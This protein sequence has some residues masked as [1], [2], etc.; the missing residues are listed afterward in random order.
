MAGP[1]PMGKSGRSTLDFRSVTTASGEGAGSRIDGCSGS[2]H[3]R[4]CGDSHDMTVVPAK[5][6]PA[7]RS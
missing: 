7:T 2:A 3:W 6:G 5:Q 4:E 1:A